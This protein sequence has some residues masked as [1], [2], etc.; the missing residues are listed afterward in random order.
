MNDKDKKDIIEAIDLIKSSLKEGVDGFFKKADKIQKQ[1]LEDVID[2]ETSFVLLLVA[3][4]NSFKEM[5]KR[6]LT[7]LEKK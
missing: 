5:E 1:I 7:E 6:I 2:E 4:K 3:F